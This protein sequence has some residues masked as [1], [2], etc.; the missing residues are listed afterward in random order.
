MANRS[1]LERIEPIKKRLVELCGE[2][3]KEGIINDVEY[4]RLIEEIE[5]ERIRI[6]VVGQIKSGKSTLLNAL[7]FGSPILPAAATPMTA[8]LTYLTYSKEPYAEVEFYSKEE[9]KDIKKLAELTDTSPEVQAAKELLEKLEENKDVKAQLSSLLGKKIKIKFEEIKEYVGEG[10]RYVPITKAL[11]IYYPHERLKEVDFV[12]TPGFNDPIVSRE[13]RANEFLEQADAVIFLIYIGRPFDKTD[14]EILFERLRIAGT[15]KVIVVLNKIDT[16]MEEEEKET[17]E[18]AE[19]YVNEKFKEEVKKLEKENPLF[20]EI[21]KDAKV[22]SFS[23]LWAL[24]GRMDEDFIKR[25]KN[26]EWYYEKYKK[27]FGFKDRESFLKSSRL[28]ELDNLIEEILRKGKLQILINKTI[29]SLL[30]KYDEKLG[31]CR[32]ESQN[33]R[34]EVKALNREREEIKKEME[35]LEKIGEKM[36]EFIGE[37]IRNIKNWIHREDI[38]LAVK[39]LLDDCERTTWFPEKVWF[40]THTAYSSKCSR[41]ANTKL[42]ECKREIEKIHDNFLR[43]IMEKMEELVNDIRHE[44]I[45]LIK[46]LYFTYDDYKELMD[47]LLKLWNR[48]IEFSFKYE[49]VIKTSGWWFIGTGKAKFEVETQFSRY[50]DGMREKF[51]REWEKINQEIIGTLDWLEENFDKKVISPIRNSLKSAERSYGEREKRL[52]E[53]DKRKSEIEKKIEEIDKKKK[54]LETEIKN[55]FKG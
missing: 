35:K 52:K 6:G 42:H 44:S 48:K 2:A 10:G 17:L 46:Y 33:I 45:N 34:I 13:K 50:V 47:N 36:K 4:S 40:Q 41:I 32:E 18:K 51:R 14:K 39:N 8:S 49:A 23:S 12:D 3:K 43:T 37:K 15:G 25:D 55:L 7:I 53:L 21:F 16:V 11:N 54:S 28:D 29:T 24:L 38:Y 31:E 22:I 26:L 9:W 30:G 5:K 1:I 19:E 20:A 27:E